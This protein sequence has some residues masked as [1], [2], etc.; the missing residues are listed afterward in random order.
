MGARASRRALLTAAVL[1]L[2]SAAL[3]QE[4]PRDITQQALEQYQQGMTAYR[5]GQY[6]AAIEAFTRAHALDPAPILLFNIAQAHW[7]KGNREEALTFYR[8]YLETAPD[9]ANREQIEARI[10]ELET[11]PAPATE[12]PPEVTTPAIHLEAVPPPAAPGHAQSPVVIASPEPRPAVYRR[13]LFWVVLGA[14]AASA[15]VTVALFATRRG[16]GSWDCADC[17]WSAVSVPGR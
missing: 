4:P 13:P 11:P 8:R 10:R 7:K 12:P 16:Q 15:A 9:A 17:N 5:S 2:A 1:A 6:S 3:A 14:V